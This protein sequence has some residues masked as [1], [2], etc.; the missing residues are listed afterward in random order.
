M[1]FNPDKCM[2]IRITNKRKDTQ[3]S[4]NIYGQ[5][6]KETAQ[7]KYLGATIDIVFEQPC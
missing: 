7:A 2:H 5:T 1:T 3:T 6:L 4:Y